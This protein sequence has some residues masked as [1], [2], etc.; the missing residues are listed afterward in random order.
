MYDVKPDLTHKTRLVCDGSRV[1]PRGLSTRATVVKGVFVR[2]I[3]IIA[4][5]QNLKVM[6]GDIFN[7]FIQSHTKENI[8]TKCGPKLGDKAGSIATIIRALYGLTT[9][10]ERF[11][12]ILADFLRTLEFIPSRFDRDVWMK[13]RG[14]KT[15]YDYTCTHV[16]DFK[17]VA[18]DPSGLTALHLCFY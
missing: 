10:A 2:L 5:Y 11:K 13:L 9:S 1:D 8:Y 7:A 18:N 16:N 17:V 12:T 4:D 3:D 15:G 6:K 14:Y